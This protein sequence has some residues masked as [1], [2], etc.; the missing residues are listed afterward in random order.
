MMSLFSES[1]RWICLVVSV[2]HS[3]GV[4][5]IF[6]FNAMIGLIY[7]LN[8]SLQSSVT[9]DDTFK[10]LMDFR[11]DESLCRGTNM[12]KQVSCSWRVSH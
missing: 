5:L 2:L 8:V 6:T 7:V 10:I 3:T 11:A 12:W 4:D 9:L 1:Y